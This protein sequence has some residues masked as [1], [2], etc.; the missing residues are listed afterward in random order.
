MTSK[1][2]NSESMLDLTRYVER[3]RSSIRAYVLEDH[4]HSFHAV[5]LAPLVPFM[6]H[7]TTHLIAWISQDSRNL[8]NSFGVICVPAATICSNLP[9]FFTT[10]DLCTFC[11]FNFGCPLCVGLSCNIPVGV[12]EPQPGDDPDISVTGRTVSFTLNG[13]TRTRIVVTSDPAPIPANNVETVTIFNRTFRLD[14]RAG[15][16]VSRTRS[17]IVTMTGR[18]TLSNISSP[19]QSGDYAFTCTINTFGNTIRLQYSNVDTS[20]QSAVLKTNI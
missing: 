17:G 8:Q 14:S 11:P 3:C 5:E 15:T 13:A 1:R 9:T 10:G 18:G 20:V 6:S 16:V 2:L 4:A 7:T 19:T 12:R